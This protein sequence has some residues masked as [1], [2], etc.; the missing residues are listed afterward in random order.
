MSQPRSHP[1][2]ILNPAQADAGFAGR[3]AL[4]VMAKAPVPG[5]VKTRLSPPLRP[6]EAAELNACFLRDTMASLL[7]A[8][9]EVPATVVISYTPAGAEADFMG[10]VPPQVVLLPQRGDLFGERL[11]A[12]AQDLFACGFSAVCLIDSDSPTVPTTEFCRAVQSLLQPARRA[13][14]GPS[15]D[16]GYY[17]IGLQSAE[18]QVFE[19]IAWSTAA[20]AGQ[21]LERCREIELPVTLLRGWYDVDDA[22][23]LQHLHDEFAA[24]GPGYEAP[25]TREYLTALATP[26]LGVPAVEVAR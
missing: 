1:Y 13:V 22:A 6:A 14:L 4:A 7:A 10:I 15:M 19:R 25:C 24:G 23:S 17:L 18:P 3:C 26:G 2:R 11:L 12:T 16:G 9:A 20:V 5:K 8:A 21:T